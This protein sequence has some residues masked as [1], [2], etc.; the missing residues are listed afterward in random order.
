MA[1]TTGEMEFRYAR[2][3]MMHS[4]SYLFGIDPEYARHSVYARRQ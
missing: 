2:R 4:T 3:T 1:L